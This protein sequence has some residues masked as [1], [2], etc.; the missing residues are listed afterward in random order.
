VRTTI[1]DD[2]TIV[3]DDARL[4]VPS[5]WAASNKPGTYLCTLP[6]CEYRRYSHSV[7]RKTLTVILHCTDRHI[8]C[9]ESDCR[10]CA[11]PKRTADEK[12]L[13]NM[14]IK[15]GGV[16]IPDRTSPAAA[17]ADHTSPEPKTPREKTPVEKAVK[18]A[19]AVT[20]WVAA[21]MPNRSDAE[22]ERIY[23][24]CNAP[25]KFFRQGSQVC[26]LCGCRLAGGGSAWKNKIRMATETCPKKYW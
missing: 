19:V 9:S 2:G 1:K 4:R 6:A 10:S 23:G 3:T 20:R 25:C 11:E 18:Y 12:R 22:V 24:I 13:K 16:W 14:E 8:N 5:L 17:I 15:E 7:H 21:G 26:R